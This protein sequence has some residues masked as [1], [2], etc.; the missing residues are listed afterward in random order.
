MN[1]ALFAFDYF[2]YYPDK[3]A[4]AFNR[5]LDRTLAKAVE[6]AAPSEK[7]LVSSAI[8]LPYVYT[9]FY[10][11]IPPR[12]FQ[13]NARYETN[14]EGIY[15][16]HSLGRFYFDL[17]AIGTTRG[18]AFIYLLYRDEEEVCAAPHRMYETKLWKVGSCV[19]EAEAQ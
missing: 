5:G 17:D 14:A 8:Q 12:E 2:A 1:A 3:A 16:V 19:V 9:A 13:A 18:V 10:L 4:P 15:V 6:L 11:K 7:I